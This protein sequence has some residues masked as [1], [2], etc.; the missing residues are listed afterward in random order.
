MI[1]KKN[2]L[3]RGKLPKCKDCPY[4]LGQIKC[5]VDS[6]PSCIESGNKENP[7]D[8]VQKSKK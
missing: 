2:L 6:C 5:L 7:F 8:A 1:S 3:L 4:H